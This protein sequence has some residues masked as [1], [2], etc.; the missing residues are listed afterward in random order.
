M[1]D[2]NPTGEGQIAASDGARVILYPRLASSE[3]RG[4]FNDAHKRGLTI[5]AVALY[6]CSHGYVYD[7]RATLQ[8]KTWMN[9]KLVMARRPG[10]YENTQHALI[11]PAK[12]QVY[13]LAQFERFLLGS[14]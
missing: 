10:E 4:Q 14:G 3:L 1:F 6:N 9:C 7:W 2:F 11:M 8:T 13:T 12:E 5:L